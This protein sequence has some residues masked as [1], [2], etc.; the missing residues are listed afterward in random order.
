MP[1]RT[2]RACRARARTERWT[3]ERLEREHILQVLEEL[4]GNQVR[5]A[6]VL[7]IDRRTLHRKLKQY[8]GD[9]SAAS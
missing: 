1:S 8:R 7:G 6:E 5:A 4:A 9:G 2:S 3:L